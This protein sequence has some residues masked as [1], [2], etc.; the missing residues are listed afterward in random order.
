MF[1]KILIYLLLGI[2]TESIKTL[3]I[4]LYNGDR[5]EFVIL[6]FV[7]NII[8]FTLFY[9]TGP[10]IVNTIQSWRNESLIE[11]SC[12]ICQFFSIC[13]IICIIISH[14]LNIILICE[15]GLSVICATMVGLVI[16]SLIMKKNK[17]I[18]FTSIKWVIMLFIAE[19][20]MF[21]AGAV[22]AV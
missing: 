21:G 20:T 18:T 14:G 2:I 6:K 3:A 10:F 15:V 12:I 1:K 9:S 8:A 13:M 16:V 17:I 7:L 4:V 11:K 22:V 19:Y 5:Y